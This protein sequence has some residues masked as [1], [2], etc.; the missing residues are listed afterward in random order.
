MYDNELMI[1]KNRISNLETHYHRLSDFF[2]ELKMQ[3]RI[4]EIFLL[5][6]PKIFTSK[7]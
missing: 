4:E 5:M 7:T 3:R 2:N 6:T 1:L